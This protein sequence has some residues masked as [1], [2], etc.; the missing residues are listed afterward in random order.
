[1]Y[2]GAFSVGQVCHVWIR[3][4]STPSQVR[5][6][7]CGRVA[8][9]MNVFSR[10][11]LVGIQS[12]LSSRSDECQCVKTCRIGAGRE[13][14]Q[15]CAPERPRALL[16]CSHFDIC[17]HCLPHQCSTCAENLP[18]SGKSTI[19]NHG[20]QLLSKMLRIEPQAPQI[21]FSS[22]LCCAVLCYV[23]SESSS[24]THYQTIAC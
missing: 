20:A 19:F 7:V 6:G 23:S 22:A 21:K 5:G 18:Y 16:A 14:L 13:E 2:A 4:S 17:R 8:F 9:S 12:R 15:W 24:Y 3:A 11:I 1:M 10:S